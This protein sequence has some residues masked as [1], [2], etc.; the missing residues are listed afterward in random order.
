AGAYF[1]AKRFDKGI[2]LLE[3]L[4]KLQKAR[5]GREHPG[6][7]TSML[8]LAL[9]YQNTGR[10]DEALPLY[11]E[12]LKGYQAKQAD[13][14]EMLDTLR[15][16]AFLYWRRNKPD[17]SV[18]LCEE[19]LERLKKKLGPEHPDVLQALGNL[20]VYYRDAGRLN[21]GIRCQEEAM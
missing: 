7:L 19:L 11:E 18:P 20:G 3:D 16:L 1:T 9:G 17:C 12:A 15:R 14:P 13:S 21:D 4:V 2:P 10:L 8:G 5:L 6:T